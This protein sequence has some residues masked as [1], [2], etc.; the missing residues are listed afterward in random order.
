M[1]VISVNDLCVDY[2]IYGYRSDSLKSLVIANV[3]KMVGWQ[4]KSVVGATKVVRALSDVTFSA[5][6]GDKIGLLGPNGSGKTTLLYVLNQTLSPTSGNLLVHGRVTSML[7]L[8]CGVDPNLSGIDNIN[9][10]LRI[11]DIDRKVRQRIVDDIVTASGLDEFVHLPLRIYSSGMVARLLFC[12]A[13]A[14]NSDIVLMDEWLSVGDEE[15]QISA[16]KRLQKFV[17]ESSILVIASHN[18]SFVGSLCNK[19]LH[20]E[21][22]R[23]V[24]ST[25]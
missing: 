17:D 7:N 19:V 11:L 12:M 16:Q 13:T 3:A 15:F 8:S 6:E 4:N 14:V 25:G 20:L 9:F 18:K 5:T 24:T 23:V 2:P 10:R 1:A 21:G 22:G